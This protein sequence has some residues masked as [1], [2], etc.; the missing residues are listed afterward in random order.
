M[1]DFKSSDSKQDVFYRTF[2][3]HIQINGEPAPV[4]TTLGEALA[5][6]NSSVSQENINLVKVKEIISG[7]E[8]LLT[9]GRLALPLWETHYSHGGRDSQNRHRLYSLGCIAK[10]VLLGIRKKLDDEDFE[11]F[12]TY[13]MGQGLSVLTLSY[14]FAG[15]FKKYNYSKGKNAPELLDRTD[16]TLKAL[17][18]SVTLHFNGSRT[19]TSGEKTMVKLSS[20][21]VNPTD[22]VSIYQGLATGKIPSKDGFSLLCL[23]TSY[24]GNHNLTIMPGMMQTT[25]TEYSRFSP[26]GLKKSYETLYNVINKFTLEGETGNHGLRQFVVGSSDV[27][28]KAKKSGGFTTPTFNNSKHSFN[29]NMLGDTV[30]LLLTESREVSEWQELL[31][32]SE[33]FNWEHIPSD[34]ELTFFELAFQVLWTVTVTDLGNIGRNAGIAKSNDPQEWKLGNVIQHL[35]EMLDDNEALGDIF[36][37]DDD[38]EEEEVESIEV[39]DSDDDD[40]DLFDFDFDV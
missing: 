20:L 33:S 15:S 28:P 26:E 1:D 13:V 11:A 14:D 9:F 32:D 18:G 24:D 4:N 25:G 12:E 35:L 5:L 23:N 17:D 2:Q 34:A 7:K 19:P 30:T 29:P 10:M 21:G 27:K 31:G 39:S 3:S 8:G 37:E 36:P 6:V 16:E 38:V 22:P 40:D